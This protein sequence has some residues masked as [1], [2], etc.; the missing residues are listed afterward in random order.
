MRKRIIVKLAYSQYLLLEE[1]P[2]SVDALLALQEGLLVK[3]VGNMYP[4]EKA[5]FAPV[6]DAD[7][8]ECF[9]VSSNQLNISEIDLSLIDT[10]KKTIEENGADYR[11]LYKELEEEKNK[12]K[13]LKEQLASTKE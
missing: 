10:F 8:F 11:K 13:A 2:K 9:F 5:V 3:P 4:I 12:V 1:G 7:S 6:E